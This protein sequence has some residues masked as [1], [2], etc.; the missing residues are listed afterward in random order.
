MR[1]Q[2]T[3]YDKAIEKLE[4]LVDRIQRGEMG[5]EE[6][7]G[8]VKSALDLIKQCRLKLREIETDLDALLE[9]E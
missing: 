4:D 1:K 5:L 6:M 9:E 3:D 7:R 2:K 8:E